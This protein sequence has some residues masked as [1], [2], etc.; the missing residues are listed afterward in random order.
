MTEDRATL[1]TSI[2][3]LTSLA[4]RHKQNS[5]IVARD[6]LMFCVEPAWYPF[7][8]SCLMSLDA[9]HAECAVEAIRYVL[10]TRHSIQSLLDKD[11]FDELRAEWT[12]SRQDKAA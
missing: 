1:A 3:T 4:T 10:T 11:V 6:V 9:K 5:G 2:E 12:Q 7:D 8:P